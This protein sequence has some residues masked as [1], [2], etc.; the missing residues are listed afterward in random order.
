M[1]RVGNKLPEPFT[2]FGLLFL[3]VVAMSTVV[4]PAW[5]ST[6]HPEPERI[7]SEGHLWPA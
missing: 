7:T 4:A 5:A 6:S 3:V 2:L 1:E